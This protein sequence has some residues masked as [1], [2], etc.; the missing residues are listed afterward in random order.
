MS[1]SIT[2]FP[3][4]DKGDYTHDPRCL[5][6]IQ[7]LTNGY[8]GNSNNLTLEQVDAVLM[9]I[10]EDFGDF[11]QEQALK[12]NELLTIAGKYV[13]TLQLLRRLDIEEKHTESALVNS[14]EIDRVSK[15][16]GDISRMLQNLDDDKEE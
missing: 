3:L 16:L 13:K 1:S 12:Y 2:P 4:A 6:S 8:L 5:E 10:T 9:A 14:R 7:I 11:L 15:L